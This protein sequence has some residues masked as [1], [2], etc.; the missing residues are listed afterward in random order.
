[1]PRV[2]HC[3]A[4]GCE[5]EWEAICIDLDLAVQGESFSEVER[6]LEEAI[7]FH[8]ERVQ[9]LPERDRE[10]MLARRVPWHVRLRYAIEAFL[11]FVR[12]REGGPFE[13][14]YTMPSPA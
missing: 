6:L 8:L 4:F 7:A 3:Y 14:R 1:M 2:L 11:F 9:E 13:H 5:G 12:E 10:R